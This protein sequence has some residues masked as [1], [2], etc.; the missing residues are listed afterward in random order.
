MDLSL[1]GKVAVVTGAS[2][3][4][5]KAIAYGFAAEGTDLAICSRTEPLIKDMARD[6]SNRYHTPVHWDV[7]D[8]LVTGAAEEFIEG[9]IKRFGSV[10]ILVNNVGAGFSKAFED[11]NEDEWQHLLDL[12]LKVTIR[13]CRKVLPIMKQRGKGRI[14]NIA[15]LSG[16]VP[17]LGQ[18]GSNVAKA[19]LINFTESLAR[20]VASYGVRV[21]AVCPAAVM[22]DRWEERINKMAK[23]RKE[24]FATT[25]LKVAKSGIPVGRFGSPEDVASAVVFLAS[26]RADFITGDCLMV[27]GG[28]GRGVSLELK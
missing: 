20:E 17:R 1:K 25:S 16:R 8:L 15:A 27:D 6:L 9:T 12:N 14:V 2:R 19:A 21:N 11:L 5:G 4:I 23:E 28:I 22:T 26:E 13:C 7:R 18:I 24:D 3:G 10:D